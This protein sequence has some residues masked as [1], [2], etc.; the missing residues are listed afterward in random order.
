MVSAGGLVLWAGGASQL[1]TD[2]SKRPA[3]VRRHQ[4]AAKAGTCP[5]PVR[6]LNAT[7]Q[8]GSGACTAVAWGQ[9]FP[10]DQETQG[11]PRVIFID[12]PFSSELGISIPSVPC[13]NHGMI[14]FQGFISMVLHDEIWPRSGLLK[15]GLKVPE[16]TLLPRVV[17][18][19]K[20]AW[21]FVLPFLGLRQLKI[22]VLQGDRY[23]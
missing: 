20:H 23:S 22:F 14:F 19:E 4:R 11:R 12:S 1:Q 16:Q 3:P 18:R 10:R 6:C 5:C 8:R 13:G 21:F 7:I 2:S 9:S 15:R 17:L